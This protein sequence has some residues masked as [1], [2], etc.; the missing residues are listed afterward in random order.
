MSISTYFLTG[1][2]LHK[3]GFG[4][5]FDSINLVGIKRSNLIH[6]CETSLSKQFSAHIFMHSISVPTGSFSVLYNDGIT[7]IDL[8]LGRGGW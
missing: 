8:T 4:Y 2:V 1:S 7:I 5:N 3:I 6:F